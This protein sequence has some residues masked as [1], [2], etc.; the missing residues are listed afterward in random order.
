MLQE[1]EGKGEGQHDTIGLICTDCHG[2]IAAGTA[3][4]RLK[5]WKKKIASLMVL[6]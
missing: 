6:L 5:R 1:G 2:N 4:R 3:S